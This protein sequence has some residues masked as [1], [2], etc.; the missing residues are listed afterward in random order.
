M[1]QHGCN[2]DPAWRQEI[3]AADMSLN[4]SGLMIWLDRLENRRGN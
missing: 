2:G 1:D 3:V 4:A